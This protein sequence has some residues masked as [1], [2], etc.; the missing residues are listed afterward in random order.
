M[1]IVENVVPTLGMSCWGKLL[2]I[3]LCSQFLYVPKVST[4]RLK[5]WH[6]IYNSLMFTLVS[7]ERFIQPIEWDTPSWAAEIR[8]DD[9]TWLLKF[10]FALFVSL[11]LGWKSVVQRKKRNVNRTSS[12]T[13][14]S[15]VQS[16]TSQFS[17]LSLFI[18]TSDS[19][20]LRVNESN[21]RRDNF[22]QE[23]YIFTWDVR[24]V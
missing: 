19:S 9:G 4:S 17:L 23:S 1:N 3:V 13:H 22:N 6:R 12:G 20:A 21:F 16:N 2:Q 8:D 11:C 7:W 14:Q 5:I 15:T 10:L 24:E 18:L